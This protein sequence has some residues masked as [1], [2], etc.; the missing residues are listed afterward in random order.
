MHNFISFIQEY[1][2]KMHKLFKSLLG[3]LLER[4][5]KA[6]PGKTICSSWLLYFKVICIVRILL[7][8]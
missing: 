5:L 7:Y 1:R 2:I 8:F 4:H 3:F 6:K